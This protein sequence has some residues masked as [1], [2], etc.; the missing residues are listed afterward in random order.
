MREGVNRKGEALFPMMPY[1]YFRTLSD[2]DAKS[3]VAYLRTTPA[4]KKETEKGHVDFPVSLFVKMEPQ[5]LAGP[6]PEP[7]RAN[8]VAYGQ[9][10]ANL[11]CHECH[12]PVDSHMKPIAGRDFAGGREFD[13]SRMVPG[14]KVASA[15]LTPHATGLGG[16][17]KENFIAQFKSF[18]DGKQYEVKVSGEHNTLMPWL[19]FAKMTEDD[20]GAIWE[21]LQTVPPVE[22]TVD[23]RPPPKFASAD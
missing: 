2:E 11:A 4:V 1:K 18:E 23:R 22:N 21:Y 9:Y 10:L 13:F 17:T 7:D 3:I 8:P 16:R 20:L 15:N 5:P 6:V 12:T 14:F 19:D